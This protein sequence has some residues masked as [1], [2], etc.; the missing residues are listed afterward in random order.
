MAD[1]KAGG[2]GPNLPDDVKPAAFSAS[3]AE[4]IED[5]LN[6]LLVGEGR[7]SLLTNDNSA[8]TRD[9]RLLFCAI[10]QGV[11]NYL[12]DNDDAFRVNLVFDGTGHVTSASI[13]IRR[14]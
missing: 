7:D 10:A 3:M 12:H 11:V 4:A 2:L 13:E 14:Q 1:L 6:T 8:E 5:A 9:R